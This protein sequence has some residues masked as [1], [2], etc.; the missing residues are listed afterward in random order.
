MFGTLRTR[1]IFAFASVTLV[2]LLVAL[3]AFLFV[4]RGREI[5]AARDRIGR[6]VNP[7]AWEVQALSQ[8]GRTEPEI[9]SYL[10]DQAQELQVRFL[11]LDANSHVLEDSG[12]QLQGQTLNL[13][14]GQGSRLSSSGAGF[15]FVT[16]EV[17]GTRQVLYQASPFLPPSLQTLPIVVQ[18]SYRLLM[19]V[20]EQDLAPVWQS[21]A[22]GIALAAGAGLLLTVLLSFLIARSIVR[23]LARMTRASEEMA[24]GRYQQRIEIASHDEVGR[25]AAAFNAMA[26]QVSHSDQMMRDLLANV[27]HELKTPLTSIQGFSQALIEA[28][29]HSTEEY[30]RAGRIINEEA[31]R[32]RRLVEDLLY[33]SQIES[34][35]VRMEHE[36]VNVRALLYN[37]LERIVR[38]AQEAGL[39]LRLQ[40]ADALPPVIGDERRLEQVVTNLLD[41]ALRYTPRGGQIRLRARFQQGKIEV[42]VHNTGSYI[43]PDELSRVFE[44][45]YRVDR[46]RSG[47]NGGLGLAIVAEI[48]AA[49]GGQVQAL[50]SVDDGTE[51]R[52]TLPVAAPIGALLAPPAL[53]PAEGR[54]AI[55]SV[56]DRRYD[57]QHL[58]PGR[59]V[60]EEQ[61]S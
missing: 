20:P 14:K 60:Q 47:R 26:E 24:R 56:T 46:A 38:R 32:M 7:V 50:S 8:E 21:L 37:C 2:S 42:S 58:A 41:N 25:L 27:A 3:V 18:V 16:Q 52:F 33:L 15:S 61:P 57:E 6:L 55:V 53:P 35:Q 19:V 11:L 22:P 4:I 51:F 30:E 9:A 36:P 59:R 43:P 1:L 48:V 54:P 23:P 31:E 29:V 5:G 40:A 12:H 44:R 13:T 34:G 49:H 45:F 39:E 17:A 10:N 28:A